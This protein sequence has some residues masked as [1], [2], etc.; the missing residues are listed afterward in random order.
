MTQK[1]TYTAP[2]SWV[3]QLLPQTV[4]AQSTTLGVD[5]DE[6]VNASSKSNNHIWSGKSWGEE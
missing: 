3:L 4:L 6:D 5:D 2:H 1:K